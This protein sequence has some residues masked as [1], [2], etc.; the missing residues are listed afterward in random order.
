MAVAGAG[1]NGGDTRGSGGGGAGTPA[2]LGRPRTGDIYMDHREEMQQMAVME[3]FKLV[4]I[5][6]VAEVLVKTVEMVAVAIFAVVV[7]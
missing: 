2:G 6:G 7:A 3:E 5:S 4:L 1:S